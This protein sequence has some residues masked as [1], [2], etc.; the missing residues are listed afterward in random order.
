MWGPS[1]LI[2]VGNLKD[3]DRTGRMGEITVPTLFTCWRYDECTLAATA[4][5]H[6]LMPV[7]EMVV[8]E[9]SAHLPHLEEPELYLQV[10]RDFLHRAESR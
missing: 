4:W 9:Q 1:D 6:E 10:V 7:S 2:C 3:Y 8:F 5:Y